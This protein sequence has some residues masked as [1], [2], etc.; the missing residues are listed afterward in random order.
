MTRWPDKL[1]TLLKNSNRLN[2]MNQ[3]SNQINEYIIPRVVV[4]VPRGA[5]R[6]PARGRVMSGVGRSGMVD[7]AVQLVTARRRF[8]SG[9]SVGRHVQIG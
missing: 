6:M 4:L 3:K 7:D 1:E 5:E 2:Q 8:D 9:T